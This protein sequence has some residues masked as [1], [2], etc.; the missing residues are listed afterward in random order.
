MVYSSSKLYLY[1][2]RVLLDVAHEKV[3]TDNLNQLYF[4]HPLIRTKNGVAPKNNLE[5]DATPLRGIETRITPDEPSSS[6]NN[7]TERTSCCARRLEARGSL[8]SH[9]GQTICWHL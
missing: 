3:K 4:C 2:I 8:L 5:R 9:A 6:R 1:V 7:V